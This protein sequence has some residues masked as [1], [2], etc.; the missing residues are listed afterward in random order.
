MTR[1]D[2]NLLAQILSEAVDGIRTEDRGDWGYG[3]ADH[4]LEGFR[5]AVESLSFFLRSENP[6]FSEDRFI[7]ACGL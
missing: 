5:R 2:Y 4:E 3:D 7:Q 1:K 6:R